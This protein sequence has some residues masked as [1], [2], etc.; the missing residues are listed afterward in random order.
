MLGYTSRTRRRLVRSMRSSAPS[1]MSCSQSNLIPAFTPRASRKTIYSTSVPTSSCLSLDSPTPV[2]VEA[3]VVG[4]VAEEDA[5]AAE[6]EEA[7]EVLWEEVA[8]GGDL[9]VV[10]AEVSVVVVDSLLVA[11]GGVAEV[12]EEGG[13]DSEVGTKGIHDVNSYS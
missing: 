7:A 6:V 9:V 4:V 11:D 5:A 3:V 10:A 2:V 1:R 12:E 13:D 8:E